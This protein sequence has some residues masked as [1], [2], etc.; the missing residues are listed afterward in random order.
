MK[1]RGGRRAASEKLWLFTQS[2]GERPHIDVR[3]LPELK[4]PACLRSNLTELGWHTYCRGVVP[5][6]V[7]T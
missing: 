5:E 2:V 1:R 6:L 4:F 7:V 3:C